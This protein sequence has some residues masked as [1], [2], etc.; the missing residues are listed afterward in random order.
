MIYLAYKGHK[1]P[2]GT[3]DNIIIRELKTLKGAIKRAERVLKTTKITV[4]ECRSSLFSYN[5]ED[6]TIVYRG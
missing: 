1:E 6:W 3:R 2:M 5:D 4:L